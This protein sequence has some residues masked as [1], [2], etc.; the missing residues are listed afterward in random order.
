MFF[1]LFFS[2]LFVFF[3]C[4]LNFFFLFLAAEAPQTFNN[5]HQGGWGERAGQSDG[6][7]A[8]H[9]SRTPEKGQ[10]NLK[11]GF[12]IFSSDGAHCEGWGLQGLPGAPAL[13]FCWNFS[14][15][16]MKTGGCGGVWKVQTEARAG[17]WD[18]SCV[19]CP[20][21]SERWKNPTN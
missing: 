3:C 9:H 18:G 16:R 5:K 6:A 12:A 10:L 1:F 2:L 21:S 13:G 8:T 20:H 4:F 11:S 7:M 15:Q 19:H 17:A 14:L